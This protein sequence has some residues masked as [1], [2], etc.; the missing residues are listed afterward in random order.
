ME[1]GCSRLQA[2]TVEYWRQSYAVKSG[3]CAHFRQHA[4]SE[5][6]GRFLLDGVACPDPDTAV[7]DGAVLDVLVGQP[8]DG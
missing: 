6:P 2:A 5:L 8:A 1:E 3:E 4:A 7:P